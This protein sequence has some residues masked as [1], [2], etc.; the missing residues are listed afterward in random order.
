MM[1][2]DHGMKA[3]KPRIRHLDGTYS[4]QNNIDC[5][6]LPPSQW[7]DFPHPT[8]LGPTSTHSEACSGLYFQVS[9]STTHQGAAGE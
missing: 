3:I 6:S 5:P 9:Q 8:G 2:L 7:G 4:P 1:R